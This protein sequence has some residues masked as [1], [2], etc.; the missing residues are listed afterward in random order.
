MVRSPVTLNLPLPDFSI[1]VDL[2]VMVGY[3]ATSKKSGDLRCPS[4]F[5]SCVSIVLASMV[6]S[7]VLLVGVLSS[8]LTVPATLSKRPFTVDTIMWRTENSV[9]ECDESTSQTLACEGAA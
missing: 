4:R 9:D 2:K 7:I 8:R 1:F 6:S 3:L 5:G